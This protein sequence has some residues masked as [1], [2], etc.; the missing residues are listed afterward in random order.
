VEIGTSAGTE[1]AAGMIPARAPNANQIPDIKSACASGTG[2]PQEN[3]P[4]D[5]SAQRW[6]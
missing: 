4:L 2:P 3:K 6:R 1:K 5:K